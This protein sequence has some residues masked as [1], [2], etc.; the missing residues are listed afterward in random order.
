MLERQL[1]TYPSGSGQDRAL[2]GL[3][4]SF[5]I[6]ALAFG[7]LIAGAWLAVGSIHPPVRRS[8]PLLPPLFI[9]EPPAAVAAP[10]PK[11]SRARP[12]KERPRPDE[13]IPRMVQPQ[14]IP[15]D[16]PEMDLSEAGEADEV[17]EE[18]IP[19]GSEF[20]IPGGHP[21][22][23]PGGVAHGDPN[24]VLGGDPHGTGRDPGVPF[25]TDEALILGGEIRK[26]VKI[27]GAKPDYPEHAR[28]ARL[29]GNVSLEVIVDREGRVES[30]RVLSGNEIFRKAAVEAVREWR[31]RPALQNGTPVKVVMSVLVEFKLR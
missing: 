8:R 1:S 23:I 11:S 27:Y 12:E 26:P 18:G 30:V 19:E 5:G 6:H 3:S 13:P 10:L 28:M 24:G 29:Q 17:W 9:N 14:I 21:D 31:Y 15:E 25:E 22:G 16:L 7:A 20:G 4:F 2:L